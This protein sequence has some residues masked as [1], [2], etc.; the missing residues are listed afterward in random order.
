MA[1]FLI[2]IRKAVSQCTPDAAGPCRTVAAAD[3]V[4]ETPP[5]PAEL[6][7]DQQEKQPSWRGL[8]DGAVGQRTIW[9]PRDRMELPSL[10]IPLGLLP[11]TLK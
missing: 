9:E 11:S 6:L 7:P 10:D 3:M 5:Q 4:G 2:V 1:C 8:G